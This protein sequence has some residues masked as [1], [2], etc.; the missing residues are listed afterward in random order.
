MHSHQKCS[1]ARAHSCSQL[2]VRARLEK[3]EG[4][5]VVL[6]FQFHDFVAVSVSRCL[7]TA[8]DPALAA[9]VCPH[10]EP[11]PSLLSSQPSSRGPK[12]GPVFLAPWLQARVVKS[13]NITILNVRHVLW[14]LF[15]HSRIILN[16]IL[17]K[18]MFPVKKALS[19]LS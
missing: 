11:D 17:K 9:P 15:N 7:G 10:T 12:E 2:P 18:G 8:G 3:S 19:L 13:H 14:L 6:L 4:Q 16:P 5:E 1:A